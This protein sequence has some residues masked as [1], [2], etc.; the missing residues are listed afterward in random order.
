MYNW[1]IIADGNAVILTNN[2][3]DADFDAEFLGEDEASDPL[4]PIVLELSP[5]ACGERLDKVISKLVPQ[6][7]RG[8]LQMWIEDGFVTVD[9]L[10]LIHI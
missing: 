3:L 2:E 9:G 10:S 7:S 1:L 5:E 6:Y 8:R 4:A